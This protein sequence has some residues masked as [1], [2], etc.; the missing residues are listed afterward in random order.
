M[1]EVFICIGSNIDNRYKYLKK[2][3]QIIRKDK[4]FKIE[5]CSL[6]YETEAWG[7]TEQKDFLN[8]VL[9]IKTR[10]GPANLLK[11]LKEIEKKAGRK[12]FGRWEEREVD[13]DIL[14][15]DNIIYDSEELQIPHKE[16]H[17]RNFV[18]IPLNE[19]APDFIHP[20]LKKPLSELLKKSK[21]KL[22]VKIYK[23]N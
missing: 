5:K 14:I 1:A 12:N 23:D 20:V 22:K 3:V 6:I 21:D 11:R 16:L 7:K 2:A 8:S 17:K 10:L 19:I 13:I 9:K 18:L 4:S 15:Y